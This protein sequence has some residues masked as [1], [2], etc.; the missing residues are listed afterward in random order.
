VDQRTFT[1][2]FLGKEYTCHYIKDTGQMQTAVDFLMTKDCLF[3]IDTETAATKEYLS[4]PKAGL[5]PHLSRIRLL[6]IFDGTNV[7]IF[8][9]N[10]HRYGSNIYE[11]FVPL[12]SSKRFVAH[13][14]LFDLQRFI[15]MGVTDM[16]LHCTHIMTKLIQHAVY[17]DDSGTGAGLADV[18]KSLFKVDILK[19]AQTSDWA[20]DELTFEQIE[21]AALD[22]I[23]CLAVA[24]KLVQGLDKFNLH[25][26]YNLTKDAQHPLAMMQLIGFKL[27]VDSHRSL[28]PVWTEEMV[29][30]KKK[31]EKITKITN[32]TGPKIGL[33]LEE[34]LD[35]FTF[36][37][38]PRT[39]SGKLS[40][41]A[42][43]FADFS[44]LD[45][46][47]PFSE[48]QKRAILTS[49][50]GHNLLNI[51][52]PYSGR[53]H[54]TFNLAGARTG[55]L[56]SSAPN[57]QNM[58]RDERIRKNFIPEKGNLLLCADYSQ[59]EL[60]V[61]AEVS[62]DYQMLRAYRE[63]IDLHAL[64]A[65]KVVG[66]NI[67]DVTKKERQIGKALG[68]GLLYGLGAEKFSHYVKKGYSKYGLSVSRDEA[69]I[70]IDKYRETYSGFRTWQ[71]EQAERCK[72]SLKART[73][74]GKQRKLTEKNYYGGGLNVPIQG[75]AAE[76][77][78][79]ALVRLEKEFRGKGKLVNCVHDEVLI[80]IPECEGDELLSHKKLMEECMFA[81][82][83]DVFPN[84]T[85]TNGLVDAS[86]GKS[87]AA[88]KE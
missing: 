76:I 20:I 58:P 72:L 69:H 43:T 53:L 78:L 29:A 60:R 15:Q 6:Q 26:I 49:T 62:Q 18:C 86:V 8:D 17:P 2:S 48:Y 70:Y 47:E 30:A 74:F 67:K 19:H 56:S 75:A 33:W 88:A 59:I 73:P 28:I 66:K 83:L 5:S 22:V 35:P 50:F 3:A 21:Y 11:M 65:S 44:H 16:N 63:G 80:E 14:G 38:W 84:A 10:P 23:V 81:A 51:V 77:M 12:L 13:Y 57:F 52:N 71:I 68:L 36:K 41:S 61:A 31:V 42:D 24:E 32:L 55:R 39:S 27:D 1:T 85:T 87:W 34:N 82:Y 79:C 4:Y 64:T 37:I 45:I 7:C 9:L 25:K 54:S 40:T 46:V